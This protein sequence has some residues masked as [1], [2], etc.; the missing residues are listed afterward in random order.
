MPVVTDDLV[1][2]VPTP[3]RAIE[4]GVDIRNLY[5]KDWLDLYSA[6]VSPRLTKIAER[7]ILSIL[8]ESSA[9]VNT[10]H[11]IVRAE[12]VDWEHAYPVVKRITDPDK[13]VAPRERIIYEPLN[14]DDSSRP[15]YHAHQ[16]KPVELKLTIEKRHRWKLKADREVSRYEVGRNDTCDYIPVT[17]TTC[18]GPGDQFTIFHYFHPDDVRREHPA[19]IFYK[20]NGDYLRF[21]CISIP[22]KLISVLV[23]KDEESRA[24]DEYD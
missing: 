2:P 11:K 19:R 18:F 10:L 9:T 14:A 16:F 8:R 5:L 23:E 3:K 1:L 17:E 6:N 20:T 21:H 12:E 24:A 7:K 15:T 4:K 22:L 13:W